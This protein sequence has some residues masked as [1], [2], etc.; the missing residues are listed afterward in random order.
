[1]ETLMTPFSP[2]FIILT[3]CCVVTVLLIGIGIADHKVVDIVIIR[4]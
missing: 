3:I 4:S 2:R 1:M